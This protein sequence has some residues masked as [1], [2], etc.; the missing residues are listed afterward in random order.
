MS[1][2]QS[3]N[4]VKQNHIEVLGKE[5]GEYYNLLYNEILW[6]NYRW[7]EYKELFGKKESRIEVLNESAPH[8]FYIIQK[9][10]WESIILGITRI[11]ENSVVSG[12]QTLSIKTLPK[13]IDEANFNNEIQLAIKS[14][15]IETKYCRDRRNR[16]IAHKDLKY[17]LDKNAKPLKPLS[18]NKI[19]KILNSF[20]NLLNL[21]ESKYF[22]STVMFDF[23]MSEK[24]A[25]SL[26]HILKDGL[27]A[28]KELFKRLD[29]GKFSER[30][31]K[32]Y[33]F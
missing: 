27:D 3:G 29:K 26:L 24:G 10:L 32:D 28:R 12:K 20:F 6:I 7:I 33:N 1:R 19:D 11:S 23:M 18:R 22:K 13:F 15:I 17:S 30:D 16:T 8:L 2:H 31:L 25:L 21:I 4:E 5:F 14:I 9:S